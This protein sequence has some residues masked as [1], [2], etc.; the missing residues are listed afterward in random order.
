MLVRLTLLLSLLLLT[1]CSK[2][3]TADA[4]PAEPSKQAE[5]AQ[6]AE[7]AVNAESPVDEL[8]KSTASEIDVLRNELD[9][10]RAVAE[11]ALAEL[12]KAKETEAKEA[13][14]A[15][16]AEDA[17]KQLKDLNSKYTT[18]VTD[19][20]KAI[21]SAKTEKEQNELVDNH[22]DK[23]FGQRFFEFAE[24]YSGT[25]TSKA[26]LKLAINQ[27]SD[28]G[29]QKAIE[30]LLELAENTD[31]EEWKSESYLL[32]ATKG[33]AEAQKT[34][35]TKVLD[36][37]EKNLDAQDAVD[38]LSSLAELRGDIDKSRVFHLL[39]QIA[40]NDIRS[41]KACDCLAQ[42][43]KSG[44]GE[45]ASGAVVRM[46]EHH[47]DSEKMLTVLASLQRALPSAGIEN[48]LNGVCEKTS[49]GKIKGQ[50][51]IALSGFLSTRDSF[52][53]FAKGAT[54]E[55]LESIGKETLDYLMTESDGQEMVRLEE[56][57]DEFISDREPLM[58]K[59]ER[60]L[61]VLQ[62]LSVGKTAPDIV[63]AD[64]D[65]VEFKL[66]D[67]RGKIVFLDF[68]GDW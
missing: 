7:S 18:A 30:K 25:E 36:E 44:S 13:A 16:A 40:D 55:Q 15:K 48:F 1:A 62:N 4:P 38:T 28:S 37:V 2:T 11:K 6:Q 35:L 31:D 24:K 12:A 45:I 42:I 21:R 27:G 65:G 39:Y 32:I 50:A 43:I 54:E 14:L 29:K 63:S 33:S 61:F 5:P 51:L 60:E 66:S 3:P 26:A 53:S 41:N 67:Y 8:A 57:L 23:E 34:A 52:A 17:K 10:Q 19:W 64:L 68:W 59:L 9:T 49:N 56:M 58:E 22:P 47:V 46:L 20:R